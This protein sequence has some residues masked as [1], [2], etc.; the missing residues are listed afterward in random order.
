MGHRSTLVDLHFLDSSYFLS[1]P[2][3][4]GHY[5][6]PFNYRYF[7]LISKS[8]ATGQLDIAREKNEW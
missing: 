1:C 3:T 6:W 7:Y 2:L 4:A 8:R 5:R